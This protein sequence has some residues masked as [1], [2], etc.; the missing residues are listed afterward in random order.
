MIALLHGQVAARGAD[1]VVLACG[2]VGYRADVSGETLRQLPA[3][4]EEGVLHTHLVVRDDALRLF[5]FYVE[6]ERDLFL[7]LTSVQAVGPK[8][9]LAVLSLGAPERVAAIIANGDV[10][11][12]R[13][14]PGVGKRTAERMV[15]ELHE[16]MEAQAGDLAGS[17]GTGTSRALARAGLCELG[18]SMAEAESLLDGAQGESVEDLI[19]SALRMARAG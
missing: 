6:R 3:V 14:V 9:A 8:L 1:H 11:R 13:E 16:K 2:G 10:P 19:A 17:D 12:L 5:G 7:L 18:Y 15:A 4:G